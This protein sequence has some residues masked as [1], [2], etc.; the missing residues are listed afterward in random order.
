MTD[1]TNPE[2][3]LEKLTINTLIKQLSKLGDNLHIAEGYI[4]EIGMY[5]A[6]IEPIQLTEFSI[7]NDEKYKY[8]LQFQFSP[9]FLQ[10]NYGFLIGGGSKLKW[11]MS[12][13]KIST[14]KQEISSSAKDWIT[15][16][17]VDLITAQDLCIDEDYFNET[18]AEFFS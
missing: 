14:F 11:Q 4:S 18:I 9:N 3:L 15:Q 5:R 8:K 1:I 2:F 7:C 13:P 6:I 16:G 17:K 12:L 10:K